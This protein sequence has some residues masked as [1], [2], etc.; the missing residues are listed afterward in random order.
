MGQKTKKQHINLS[1]STSV[2][3]SSPKKR[4]LAKS[5]ARRGN[6]AGKTKSRGSSRGTR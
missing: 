6:A 1:G 3:S 4:K 2:I 5:K